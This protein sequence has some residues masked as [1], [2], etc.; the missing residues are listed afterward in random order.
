MIRGNLTDLKT[1]TA[2]RITSASSQPSYNP[3]NGCRLVAYGELQKPC[4]T[5]L[6]RNKNY[7]KRGI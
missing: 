7:L 6:R 3:F 5:M 1:C 4:I 2:D